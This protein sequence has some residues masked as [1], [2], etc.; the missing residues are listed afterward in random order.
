MDDFSRYVLANFIREK[1]DIFEVF[2]DLC[3]CIYK[4]KGSDIVKI[5]MNMAR[6]LRT[7]SYMSFVLQK[8]P[9]MDSM[10]L[11]HL[12]KMGVVECKNRNL[13]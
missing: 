6:S 2:K 4:E 12:N 10:H 11:S 13:Q 9:V 3:L 1:Y 7:P 8:G 5:R